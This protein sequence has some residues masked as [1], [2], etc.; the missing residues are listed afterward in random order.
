MHIF[1]FFER[2]V[3]DMLEKEEEE[4]K[5]WEEKLRGEKESSQE[6][7]IGL[8]KRLRA[9]HENEMDDMEQRHEQRLE[10]VDAL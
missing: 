2:E 6:N 10:D 1:G 4:R 5:Q 9:I 3:Q 8:E 7:L